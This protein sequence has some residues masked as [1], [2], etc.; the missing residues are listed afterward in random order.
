MKIKCGKAVL[1]K[2]QEGLGLDFQRFTGTAFLSDAC[3]TLGDL[4]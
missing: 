1:Q 4:G 3:H 2:Q